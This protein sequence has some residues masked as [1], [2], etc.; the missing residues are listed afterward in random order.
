MNKVSKVKIRRLCPSIRSSGDEWRDD[1]ACVGKDVADFVYG[2]DEP[3]TQQRL[4]LE[5]IC[6]KCP[7]I[8]I[9]RKEGL[10]TLSEGW[11]GGMTE[12]E[13]FSWAAQNLFLEHFE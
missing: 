3:T 13:R 10:R 1:A 5:S 6:S 4:R 12:Q 7:V 8:I 2:S 11:W 9:C